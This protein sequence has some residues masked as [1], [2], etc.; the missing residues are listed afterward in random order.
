M[1]MK[2]KKTE[3]GPFLL[4]LVSMDPLTSTASL[5]SVGNDLNGTVLTCSSTSELSP[6]PDQTSD[7]V[8]HLEGKFQIILLLVLYLNS[9]T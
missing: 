3:I 9:H 7:I 6:Q 8:L 4:T 1:I 2:V 5:N